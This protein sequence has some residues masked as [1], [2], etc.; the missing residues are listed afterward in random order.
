LGPEGAIAKEMIKRIKA[1]HV[2]GLVADPFGAGVGI[3]KENPLDHPRHL[4]GIGT[5]LPVADGFKLAKEF[6]PE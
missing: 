1:V 2:F 4:V 6:F 5:L 3:S